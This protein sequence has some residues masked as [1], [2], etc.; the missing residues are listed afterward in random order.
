[1]K[2]FISIQTGLISMLYLEKQFAKCLKSET[3]RGEE[4]IKMHCFTY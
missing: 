2:T 1:M 4:L 3:G